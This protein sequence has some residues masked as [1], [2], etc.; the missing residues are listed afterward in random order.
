MKKLGTNGV[1]VQ[2]EAKQ[3]A[4]VQIQFKGTSKKVHMEMTP[5]FE[6]D[7]V[8]ATH[9]GV[10]GI[11]QKLRAPSYLSGV[12]V[13]RVERRC[14]ALS[15]VAGAL[16][17]TPALALSLLQQHCRRLALPAPATGGRCWEFSA[18]RWCGD[19]RWVGLG[20]GGGKLGI[21]R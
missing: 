5:L 7:I 14:S 18:P 17:C 1:G 3:L 6:Q 16:R 9:F 21:L 15:G 13:F 11:F 2:N 12:P 10:S 4:C 8:N 20:T 19:W